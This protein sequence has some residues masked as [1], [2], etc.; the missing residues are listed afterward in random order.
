MKF[1]AD[2]LKKDERVSLILRELYEKNGYRKYKMS[3]LEEYSL[4]SENKSFLTSERVITFNDVDGRLLALKPDVTLSIAK[5]TNATN[6]TSEKLYYIENVFRFS[7]Q[8]MGYKEI[9]QMG[10][11]LIGGFD[12]FATAEVIYLALQ[13]LN[14]IDENFILDISH[15]G[16]LNAL[17]AELNLTPQATREITACIRMK[18]NH[19]L[20]SAGKKYGADENKLKIIADI[21]AVNGAVDES[22]AEAEKIAINEAMLD[23]VTELRECCRAI[24]EGK[25]RRNIR[26]DFSVINDLDYYSGIVFQG[27][28]GK[29]PH[30]VL[31]GGRYDPLMKKFDTD[32]GAMGFALYLDELGRYYPSPSFAAD[33]AVVYD[34]SE[35]GEV[36]F[37]A[38][39]ALISSGSKVW[40]GRKIPGDLKYNKLLRFKGGVF[41]EA[42]NA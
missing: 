25:L 22:L 7:K 42:E 12:T 10:L 14:A 2:M 19:D 20:Y 40:T 37:K 5:R 34:E 26:I 23:A 18:N 17:F 38:V 33:I 31:A 3:Q 13:S 11:E 21:I 28:A 27:F 35:N 4:Y 16:Y 1:D 6:E 32:V 36:L 30:S 41:T 29:I 24:P 39:Q 9:N 15:L 8:N